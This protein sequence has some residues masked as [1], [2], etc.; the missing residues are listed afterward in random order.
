MIEDGKSVRLSSA[1]CV[2]GHYTGK[3]FILPGSV[4]QGATRCYACDCQQFRPNESSG[5]ASVEPT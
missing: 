4:E 2:C 3:H 5:G 1:L